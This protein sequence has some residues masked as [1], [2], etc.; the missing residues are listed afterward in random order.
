MADKE[1]NTIASEQASKWEN[2]QHKTH[3]GSNKEA[4]KQ[5]FSKRS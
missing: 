3:R 2:K 1:E 4:P 5:M